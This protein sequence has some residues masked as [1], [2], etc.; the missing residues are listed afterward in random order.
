MPDLIVSVDFFFSRKIF[1]TNS[2]GS[3]VFCL[4]ISVCLFSV[5]A[6]VIATLIRVIDVDLFNMHVHSLNGQLQ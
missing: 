2:S 4:Q 3:F 1:E 5:F 6:V